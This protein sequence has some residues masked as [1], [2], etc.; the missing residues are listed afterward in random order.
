LTS[1]T[2]NVAGVY[3]INAVPN[4]FHQNRT[5]SC[6]TSIRHVDAPLVQQVLDIP[7]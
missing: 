4:R 5:V 7:K 1:T 6:A 3:I 2:R